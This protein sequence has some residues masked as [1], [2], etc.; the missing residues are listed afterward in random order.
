MGASCCGGRFANANRTDPTRTTT[1]RIQFEAEMARRFR[2]LIKM[3]EEEIVAK[4]GFGLKANAGRFEFTRSSQKVDAFMRWLKTAAQAEV[5]GV[6]P[7]TPM[8]RAAE[9]SWMNT[10][11]LSSYQ[12]GLSRAGTQLRKSGAKVDQR[13]IDSAFMRP[14]HADRVGLIYT[15]TFSDLNGITNAMDT[16]ISRVLAQGMIDGLNPQ[17]IAAQI[18][19]RVEKIGLT[20]ARVLARTEIISAHA[21]ATLNGFQEAGVQ[22]V[23]VEAEFASAADEKVCPQCEALNG[24]TVPID[25]ARG[26][27][28]V[29]PNC[30]CAW[31]PK[32]VGGTAIE[33]R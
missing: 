11:I 12:K 21:E 30:R 6:I 18:R 27:L 3:I 25:Q 9:R 14:I 7:G 15:R 20:R 10:Y 24:R 23:E 16:Q 28:P 31:M 33:L 1:L 29:H 26:M 32:V 4:D 13:W 17:S 22:G 2:R 19:D 8:E 5:L